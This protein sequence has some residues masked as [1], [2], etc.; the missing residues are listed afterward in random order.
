MCKSNVDRWW[1]TYNAAL[2]GLLGRVG[3]AYGMSIT[4]ATKLAVGA[5]ASMHASLEECRVADAEWRDAT[6]IDAANWPAG[7]ER[8]DD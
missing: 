1:D 8:D 4:E 6:P 2:T 7:V 3:P 5:A